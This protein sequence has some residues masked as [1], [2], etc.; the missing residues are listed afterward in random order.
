LAQGAVNISAARLVD[1]G[2]GGPSATG[3]ML[4]RQGSG[5]AADG[6]DHPDHNVRAVTVADDP[7]QHPAGQDGENDDE[8]SEEH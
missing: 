5:I 7:A 3:G 2:L 6:Q 1:P 8:S 4:L